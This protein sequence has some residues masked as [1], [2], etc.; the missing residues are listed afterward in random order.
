[1][2]SSPWS[3]VGIVKELDNAEVMMSL[4]LSGSLS[5]ACADSTNNER[6][7]GGGSSIQAA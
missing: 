2:V 4:S 3:C 1:M 6:R 5:C 7:R